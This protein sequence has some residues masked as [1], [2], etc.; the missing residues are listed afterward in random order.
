MQ[1]C[2]VK[3]CGTILR[4]VQGVRYGKSVEK[5]WK[6]VASVKRGRVFPT[7]VDV[8]SQLFA[9]LV[10]SVLFCLRNVSIF[11]KQSHTASKQFL[12]QGEKAVLKSLSLLSIPT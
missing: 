5:D 6:P 4:V 12:V 7:A 8:S 11:Q 10:F 2:R 1:F 3:T 9:M